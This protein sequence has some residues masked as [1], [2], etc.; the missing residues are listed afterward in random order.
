MGT[1]ERRERERTELRQAILDAARELFA[2]RGYEAVTMR[3]IAKRIEY[4]PTA[5]YGYFADKE[6]LVRELCRQDFASF[7][8][9]FVTEVAGVGQ[10]PGKSPAAGAIERMC[11]AGY[12]YLAFA[13]EYPQHYRLMFMT[14]MPPTPPE[15]GEREDP[16]VN[17][18]V[19][20]RGLVGDL[21]ANDA[22]RPELTDADLIA[23][24]IWAGVHGAAG[25]ELLTV[26]SGQWLDFR[27]REQRFFA[28]L[29][30]IARNIARDPDAAVATLSRVRDE[31]SGGAPASRAK[32]R[33][34]SGKAG[35]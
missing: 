14:E 4:S 24:S 25:L 15:E 22:L 2:T 26:R 8:Q 20:L 9:R 31:V 5:L 21:M 7:A 18:Y 29:E 30:M 19:F 16:A 1:T 11:R 33:G 17:A 32:P 28:A 34:V 10:E 6:T 12:V 27:P 3:E 35:T 13:E 23:Q